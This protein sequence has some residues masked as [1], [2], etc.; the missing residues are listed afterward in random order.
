MVLCDGHICCFSFSSISPNSAGL[1]IGQVTKVVAKKRRRKFTKVVLTLS[2][3]LSVLFPFQ[4]LWL[5]KEGPGPG[6]LIRCLA[7]L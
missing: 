2:S 3:K 5:P 4:F 7:S 1:V 6:G